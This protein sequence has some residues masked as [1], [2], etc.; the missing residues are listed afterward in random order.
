MTAGGAAAR[1]L[2][3]DEGA[4]KTA[5]STAAICAALEA[6][7]APLARQLRLGLRFIGEEHDAVP[8]RMDPVQAGTEPAPNRLPMSIHDVEAEDVTVLAAAAASAALMGLPPP[9]GG[10]PA[11]FLVGDAALLAAR[12][13]PDEWHLVYPLSGPR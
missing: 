3:G 4:G 10:T 7:L 6:K 5:A 13:S 8:C 12:A 9:T 11:S 1:A 2:G